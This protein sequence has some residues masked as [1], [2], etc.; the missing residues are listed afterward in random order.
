MR[1]KRPLLV[2]SVQNAAKAFKNFSSRNLD[3]L[4]RQNRIA[5][6]AEKTIP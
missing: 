6:R 2:K 4:F 1:V 3:I 5:T